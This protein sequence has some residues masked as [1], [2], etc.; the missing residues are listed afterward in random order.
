S[1]GNSSDIG[2]VEMTGFDTETL[3]H[4]QSS[5]VTFGIFGDARL[6]GAAG[7]ILNATAPGQFVSYTV[8][9]SKTG[10]YHIKVGVKK[11]NNKGMFQLSVNGVNKGAVQN[12]YASALTYP[13]A[14]D[15]GSV[16]FTSTGNQTF[17]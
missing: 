12:E 6:S 1:G 9:I 10:T 2:A 11:Q 16:T 13:A 14:L 15:L 17:K 4:S 5:G 8:P 7:S 3:T